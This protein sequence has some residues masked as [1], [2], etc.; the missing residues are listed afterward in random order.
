MKQ[1]RSATPN[2]ATT[3]PTHTLS[4]LLWGRPFV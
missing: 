2:P 1:K 3:T 4:Y